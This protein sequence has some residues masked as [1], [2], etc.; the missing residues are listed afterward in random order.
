MLAHIFFASARVQKT[1]KNALMSHFGKFV[2]DDNS[3]ESHEILMN[4]IEQKK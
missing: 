1:V 2:A 4:Q 3:M